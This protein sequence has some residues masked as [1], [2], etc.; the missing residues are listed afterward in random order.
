LENNEIILE[1][2]K[3]LLMKTDSSLNLMVNG[4]FIPAYEKIKGI[5]HI[6]YNMIAAMSDADK[7]RE[8]SCIENNQKES[9][10]TQ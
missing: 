8:K 7:G 2:L 5:R 1:E 10:E 9:A 3:K 6:M 4:R